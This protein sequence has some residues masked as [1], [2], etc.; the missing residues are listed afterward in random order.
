MKIQEILRALE[1][2]EISPEEAKQALARARSH[3]LQMSAP[4]ANAV[5]ELSVD[6]AVRLQPESLGHPLFQTR[7]RT[8]WSYFA[9]SMYRGI[10]SEEM[11]VRMGQAGLLAFFGS[12]GFQV[13]ELEPVLQRIQ[14]RL[15]SDKPYGMCLIANL[16]DPDEERRTAE[17]YVEYGVKAIEVSAF[18][19][20]TLPLVYL[21]LKGL[22]RQ[23]GRLIFPRRLI[24]KCSH[25]DTARVFLSP[26]PEPLVQQ[27]LRYGLISE[28]EAAL[29][30]TIPLVGDLAI[31]ADSGGHTNQGVSFS[32]LPAI[33]ALK[34]QLQRQYR[35]QEEI[36]IG[37][38][39]GIGTP[40]AV[41]SAFMLGADFI[42][43]GSINQCTVESGAHPVVKDLLQSVSIHDMAIT[44]AGDMFE[45]GAK[46]QVVK[47]HTQFAARV[48][49]LHQLFHQYNSI[50]EIPLSI[51]HE[52]ETKYFKKTFEEVWDL[53]CAYKRA[54]HPEQL[55]E[56]AENPRFKMGLIFKW[57]FA[58]S[59]QA[60]LRGDEQE[61]D[62]FQIFCGPAMGA[63]NRW[64]QGTPYES[65][66]QRHVNTV[67]E[68]LM[69]KACEHLESR[70]S[71]SV[72]AAGA[73]AV[74]S[75]EGAGIA[76]IGLSGQ[77][78]KSKNA[79]EFW[80]NLAQGR[81][82]ISEIPATR[83]SL[84]EHYSPDPSA[85]GKTYSKWMGVLEDADKFDPLF[86]NISPAEAELMDPQ[87]R[88]FLESAWQAI[89]D[90][91][92]APSSLSGSRTG[93]F[94]GC[95]TNDYGQ[96]LNHQGL[97][98]QGLMGAASSI[99]S[100]R[101]SYL[102]NL[103]G[104]CLAIDTACSSSL[105]AMAEAC[106]SL[107]L[108]TSDLALSG[109]VY[110]AAGPSL[111]IMTSKAGMLSPDGRC[112][113]FDTRAN[114]FVPGEGVGVLVLKRLEDAVRDEDSIYGVIRG[115]G[116]NQ[117]GK[118]NGITAPSVNSQI[119]LEQ[120]VYERFGIDPETI[121]LIEAHGT[122]TK[123]GD[124]IEV[125]ALTE[126]FRHFTEKTGYCALGSVKSNI[127]HL[128]T[129]A[130]VAG[131]IK[132]LLAMKHRQV[133]PTV[134]FNQ[135][136][137]HIRLA[138]SPFYINIDLIPWEVPAG[139]PRRAG[140][141][142]FG[143]SGTNAH[144]VIE[145]H[146]EKKSMAS[147]AG[148][149]DAPLLFVLSAMT[150]EQ[151]RTY[152][153]SMAGFLE[154][155]RDLSLA[156]IAYTLQTGRDA[157]EV[158]LAFV[159]RSRDEARQNFETYAEGR[160][161]PG[162]LTS[163][164]GTG[165]EEAQGIA[166]KPLQEI[167]ELWVK[168]V[169]LDW[170]ELYADSRPRRAHLPTYP[171]A[172]ERFWV[173]EPE[174]EEGEASTLTAALHPLLHSNTSKLTEQRFSSTFTGREFFLSDHQVQGRKVLP[175]VA[176]LEMARAALEQATDMSSISLK[177]VVW[178]RPIIAEEDAVSVQIGLF[179][180]ENGEIEFEVYSGLDGEIVHSQGRAVPALSDVE[181]P[182]LDLASLQAQ[183]G[184]RERGAAE[185]YDL[186]R[187]AGL[188]YGPAFQGM[189]HLYV[190]Q[191]MILA[192][193]SLPAAVASTARQF[194]LHPS[195][196]DSALQTAIGFLTDET[197]PR[198][199]LPFALKELEIFGPCTT[200]MWAF[201]RRSEGNKP[202]DKVHKLDLDLCDESGSV[203]VRMKGYSSRILDRERGAEAGTLMLRPDWTERPVNLQAVQTVYADH[204][205]M[206]CEVDA[207]IEQIGMWS[208]IL[209][210]EEKGLAQR[211][212][213]Y[214]AHAFKAIKS[215]LQ[216]RRK[217]KALVQIVVPAQGDGQVFAGLS[218]LLKTAQ[219]EN[220]NLVGQLI[221]VDDASNL[222]ET[223]RENARCADDVHVRYQGGKR[224]G[225]G[226][227]EV[228][229]GEEVLRIPWKDQGVY[230][231]TGGAG[232]L[233]RI[234]AGEIARQ[235][236]GATLVLT[237][238]G[239]LSAEKQAELQ[240]LDA[241][242]VY[243]QV[244]VTDFAGVMQLIESI[245]A[246]HGALHGILHS[247][248]VIRDNLI[249]KKT[250]A[251]LQDVLAPKVA[252]A[253]H[254]DEA[255]QHLPLDFFVTF[256]SVAG[257]IGNP[258]QA[259]YATANAF[260][261]AFAG[262]RNERVANGKRSGRTLSINWPL[263]QDGGMQ[264][265]QETEQTLRE[266]LGMIPM[267]TATGIR[268]LYQGMAAE[269]D[270]ILVVEGDLDRIRAVF[271]KTAPT[272]AAGPVSRLEEEP[273]L[274]SSDFEERA[275]EYFKTLLSSVLKM[276]AS[277]IEANA[278]FEKY[279]I[280][281]ILVMQLTNQLEKTFGSLPKTLFFE[282][283]NLRELTGY[284][285]DAHRVLL[286]QFLGIGEQEW[287]SESAS[288]ASAF[289]P[290]PSAVSS[291]RRSRLA[292]SS[293]AVHAAPVAQP[294]KAAKGEQ[295]IA[296]I[297]VSGR[298]P[299][300]RNLQEF[301]QNLR[302]GKDCITEIPKDRWDHSLY[303][304]P[305]KSKPGKTNSKWGGFIDGVDQFDPK[306]FNISPREAEIMDPQERLFLQT[307]YEAL[308][309]AG[310]TRE[311]LAKHRGL[312]L[313]GNVGVYVG[314]MYEEY[315]LYGAEETTLGRP[316]A[317]SGNPSS[318]A[319]RVSYFFNLHG[320]S[321]A[322]DTMC[323]SSLT[324]IHLACQSLQQGGC[325]LAIAGG[326]NVSIH[327]NKYL[328]LG[329]GKFASSKGRC[330]SFG[331]GGDGYVP[332]EGVGAVLLKPL[333]KAI[334]D[335]DQIHGVIKATAISHGG[336]TNGYTVPNPNAQANVIEQALR[337]AGLDPSMVSYIEAHGTGTSLGDPIE[338]AGLTKAFQAGKNAKLQSCA[339]GSAKSNIGHC[340]SAAG[341]AGVTK[342]L[343]QLK[344]RQLAPSLHAKVLNPNIDFD[345]TPF[346]VQ[347]ELA[348]W[349]RP[350][351]EIG[352]QVR[353]V[354]RSAG[355]SS[356][357]AGGSNAHV[358]IE[359]YVPAESLRTPVEVTPQ[360][361]AV[362][363]LSAKN[364]ERLQELA[365]RLL[366]AIE[367]QPFTDADLADIAYTLQIG[368]EAHDARMAL[369]V[370]SLQD[371]A[372]K[373]RA[374]VSGQEDVPTLYRGHVKANRDTL[375]LFLAD[376]ELQE[377]IEKWIQRRKHVKLVDLWVKGLELDW[378]KLYG[379]HKPRR[380]SLPTY[381][382][383]KQRYWVPEGTAGAA[384]TLM[385]SSVVE[386]LE[387]LAPVSTNLQARVQEG[388]DGTLNIELCDA[389]GNI[390][391]RLT[392]LQAE[393]AQAKPA[394]AKKQPESFELMTFRE[395]WQEQSLP[396]VTARNAGTLV[397]FLSDP[398]LQQTVREALKS[399]SPS[400][401][402]EFI[403]QGS[404]ISESFQRMQEE[405]RDVF[406]MLYLWPLEDKALIRE[407][408]SIVNILKFLDAS[409][410]KPERLLLAGQFENGVERSYFESWIG[411]ERSLGLVLPNTK[412][413]AV[414]QAGSSSLQD[415]M[416]LLWRE[417]HAP[418][419]QSVLYEAGKRH[420][421]TVQPTRL[422]A[423]Q[424]TVRAGGTYL[425]TGGLGALGYL[426]A[427]HLAQKQP[428][429]LILTG[430][431]EL[432]E[433]KRSKLSD[434]ET[435]GSQVFYLQ[436]D[437]CDEEQMRAGLV[438]ACD[439]FGPL[440]G[441][442][443]AAGLSG[444][445]S[446]FAKDIKAF[447][448]VLS[449]KI[450]GTLLLDELLAKETELDFV[451]YF[452][453]SSAVLGD[454]G[455]CDYAIGN[456]FQMAYAQHRHEQQLPGQ[457]LVINWP[458]WKEGGMGL[459]EGEI[460][461]NYLK[462]SG[463][464]FLEAEEGVKLF[465]LILSQND[466]QQLVLVGQPSRVERFLGM[467]AQAP[468]AVQPTTPPPT[469]SVSSGTAMRPELQGF[470]LEQCIEWDLKEQVS[471]ILKISRD[472]L[473]VEENLV[474]FGFDS[475]SLAEL[476]NRLSKHY[477]LEVTPALFFSHSTLE[478]L[479]L[480]F[481]R[482]HE[483]LMTQHYLEP[484]AEP[485]PEPTPVP[486]VAPA[487]QEVAV[488]KEILV[489]PTSG[490]HEPIAVIGMSGRFPQADSVQDFW[491]NLK[492]GKNAITEIPSDRWDW[493]SDYEEGK[494]TSKWGGF[495]KDV[496]CFDP[497]FFEISPRE[498]EYMDP[499]QRLFLEE[500]WHALEDAGYMGDQIRGKLCGVYVGVEEG[501]YGFLTGDGGP[502]NGNQNATLA[503]R[504]AYALDLKGPNLAL[505]AACSSGLVALHQAC[506]ALRAG[507]CDVALAGGVNLLISPMIY[508]GMS[509][510]DMLSPDGHSYVFDSRAN[511]LVPSE[512]VAVVVLKPL[513]KAIADRDQIYGC[514]TATGVNYNGQSNGITSP[515]PDAQADLIR[516]VYDRYGIDSSDIQF[517]MS[518][519]TGSKLGDPME[520]QALTSAFRK[521]GAQAQNCAL[522]SIKPLIGHT[523]AA[524]GIV[525]LISMLMA[526]RERTLLGLH[527]FESSNEYIRFEESPF[528]VS[529]ENRAWTMQE[530][531]PRV[532]AISTTG[533]SGTNA[534]AVIEEYIP[535]A[536]AV[537][538]ERPGAAQQLVILS[539]RNH[540]RLQHMAARLSEHLAS[541][542][543]RSL[544]LAQIAYTLQVGREPMK[545]RAAFIVS[546]KE[547]LLQRLQE[548]ISSPVV[549]ETRPAPDRHQARALVE[550]ALQERNLEQLAAL[551]LSGSKVPW[552]R[553]HDG[554]NVQRVS[555]PTY[556]FVKRRCW[557]E[558]PKPQEKEFAI[559]NKAADFYTRVVESGDSGFQEEY[560]TFCPFEEKIPG[561][562]ISRV[563]LNPEQYPAELE[564][565]RSKQIEMRRV[566]FSRGDFQRA[567]A[568]L[569]IGCGHGTDVIQL[570]KRYPHLKTQGLTITEAQ[571][572]LGN[573][574]IQ[575]LNLS[576]QAAIFHGD[577]SK[578]R[579]PGRYDMMIGIEVSCHIPDKQGLFQNMSSALNEGG[580]VLMMDFIAN[581][582]GA[583]ADPSIDIY[584]P[585]VQ[586]W[587]DLLAEHHLVLDEVIDVSKQVSNSLHDPEHAE[588]TKG[589]PEVVQNSIRNFANSSISLEKGWISYCLFV[590]SKNS[591]LSPAELREH[592]A[593]QMSNRTPYP[594][595]RRN[596]L[597]Q[598]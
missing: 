339:I 28:E 54:K 9:G 300:A 488:T 403:A 425:I 575:E 351:V 88:L 90:A 478:K 110:A 213:A 289:T 406:G 304:D 533:I 211:F 551:W 135:L 346:V 437:V 454:F 394:Q 232:G 337:K 402:V 501:E 549:D 391:V 259:D 580:Q 345:A 70:Q 378:N 10:A 379:E 305:D 539:A 579:F 359:E 514:I 17:L 463:Q 11:V 93:V 307:V 148:E 86:F 420:I 497:L 518:H 33:R 419:A 384:R 264:V 124:P 108:G 546:S 589:L 591:A 468:T 320:P 220:P 350:L 426:F 138:K 386:N 243:W 371:L 106:N 528:V 169:R 96:V 596:M 512:A 292:A 352:G 441:V 449:P 482:E 457:T 299:G 436:A 24:A 217:G 139:M 578:D 474:D 234:F 313:D 145:E 171:F 584:I 81:D 363:V 342:V 85:P 553:L 558:G 45:I 97:N 156:S 274:I 306:F 288:V 571:A 238:R 470:S 87:Q 396:S 167:A 303:F 21:R 123:L 443:H 458:L 227:S 49:K 100:A 6:P 248:G 310:Y 495:V 392:G 218:A 547:E 586:G 364:E 374:C 16:N 369:L 348:E 270:Q 326:V 47:K 377:A 251:E 328:L 585:T 317:L 565:V 452:S 480:H 82:C 240:S 507:D 494:I 430:R 50:D 511:G 460:T 318:I 554:K 267:Q 165:Q 543:G 67:T 407:Y 114:G 202:G 334:E 105:V 567:Q 431:S 241:N 301:W 111:H 19:A 336:K 544:P 161:L 91:G 101:I 273:T 207:E 107:L 40:E 286:Q 52:I 569:D 583:I 79:D 294:A 269:Q 146:L 308:E 143:F 338:I 427:E 201:V 290:E 5:R 280:D 365:A 588:N 53:V 523:F 272:A 26:P 597:Q 61:R 236:K 254:L 537:Q 7:Y 330:E 181:A 327:P 335:G 353:E 521:P 94:V 12:A 137:E 150:E 362:I 520:I 399:L 582:R 157:R 566:L 594:E 252:G 34:D 519:S 172:R 224:W 116:V 194:I 484:T 204:L 147:A 176:Y 36:L 572:D 475:I 271:A 412:V 132:V 253:V 319:N 200:S 438:R 340:E 175:G 153:A 125:E 506:Q 302:D 429:N 367:T 203:R 219:L 314:V 347:Q 562:S 542:A 48:N 395:I 121:S 118:T 387:V 278:P 154:R 432:D 282:Y 261:D 122:G 408:S 481:L 126:S 212:E 1:A 388:R 95:G 173:P 444:D 415:W 530:G 453:S 38:G 485:A 473:D 559:S 325:E 489:P 442:L 493:Q 246:E 440:H 574:R 149:A 513:S 64:V 187:R 69:R 414:L 590:I 56:A 516:S 35:Y 561:F 517:V 233:G 42:F 183:C 23:N 499:K 372:T 103:K 43:T 295:D 25:L 57:Y 389:Q 524:S 570:A 237:G 129:A 557:V 490:V 466:V 80:N 532:G 166:N 199:A 4:L 526:M 311:M 531:R 595:A 239:P 76:I 472:E 75:F 563:Y 117:D 422:D 360:N 477:G 416:P 29:S 502:L 496:D 160:T 375:S 74:P 577:S 41:A 393:P 250:T 188:E 503:A 312:G 515:N 266:T 225:T 366:H 256:S 355:I 210:T 397:C 193:L 433:E 587:I 285:L 189:E 196:L 128:L 349:K 552:Q 405:R 141:S 358:I 298:Y 46:V 315:Q 151:L 170:S 540:D 508:Q 445:E 321:L 163:Q 84:D 164:S 505:T 293:T 89:E 99:L 423:G 522:S 527:G 400:L 435:L 461:A 309:D 73:E 113:S 545:K 382:F 115:W 197:T 31:E 370:D 192:R 450:A 228:E 195:L 404:S 568:L 258:G 13:H 564:M 152:A 356:F 8:I 120:D 221:E 510:I 263:W 30:Q 573:R 244:D 417:L 37:C 476:G 155:E 55:E 471:Q 260:L 190:G 343:L 456:R 255:T 119:Q 413:T 459:D 131:V 500:A 71:T 226:W 20:P 112:Y 333:S 275:I 60:T 104:P 421:C 206:L 109:G 504:I 140:V 68:L 398:A 598:I 180:E 446:L 14:A 331:E 464:R 479:T 65:W 509:K 216:E 245:Q 32:L 455:S 177:N 198:L 550:T 469:V 268:A 98:A 409:G 291:R 560:L 58:H 158:R 159:A 205:V 373:L 548:Y 168:G 130:G 361:P 184:Q 265:E 381:P 368:R 257:A 242:V 77:F 316:L 418:Q 486:V 223:L 439:R 276:P 144:V 44:V 133:P 262:Y 72:S 424:R 576:A 322:V 492:A 428:V 541:E 230:L 136:N 209:Q 277:R 383:A 593:K 329:Q 538:V 525:S 231:L 324:S 15:G 186:Y 296:I 284:F 385:S 247:A 451:C 215:I 283:Q 51:R 341:I 127:G 279:G 22:S 357:G 297:G 78:P 185:C 214:A 66:Q 92:I 178:A 462:S 62:N 535:T 344:H 390:C 174:M 83:W 555:L 448:R 447:E 63:F 434:L 2:K 498:A 191:E 179:P 534:H 401:Q 411:F 3:E 380:I 529:T 235:V 483:A 323:S 465:D 39:G 592:N 27:L 287:V 556:P 536:M 376:E 134:H 487:R 182:V 467:A 332:G 162:L 354:P 281:S 59:A 581:L 249:L 229:P 410:Q 208:L 18:S 102:L 222:A 142:S 491:Q